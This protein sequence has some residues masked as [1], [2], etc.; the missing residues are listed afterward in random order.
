MVR[1]AIANTFS[2]W[3]ELISKHF[4][5]EDIGRRT[6]FAGL[7]LTVIQGA[8]IRARAERSRKPFRDAA[9]WL[10]EVADREVTQAYRPAKRRRG[11]DPKR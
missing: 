5:I 7:V 3:I 8:S 10:A 2:Q 9:G 4:P 11:R 1:V 6:S